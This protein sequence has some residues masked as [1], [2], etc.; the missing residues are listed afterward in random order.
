M[1]QAGAKDAAALTAV[2]AELQSGALDAELF[3]A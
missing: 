2:L 1:A 3:G